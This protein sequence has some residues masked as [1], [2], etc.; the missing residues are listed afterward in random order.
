MVAI[1]IAGRGVPVDPADTVAASVVGHVR[2]VVVDTDGVIVALGRRSRVFTGSC[3]EAA[4]LQAA[5]DGDGR[6]LWPGCGRRRRCQI[7]HSE[8]WGH[9]GATDVH[10][11]GPLCGFHNRFKSRGYRCTRDPMGAWHT[12]R[13]DGTEIEAA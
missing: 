1:Q 11:A 6:C 2:R 9:G 5:L 8:E 12:Y 10:N 3:R 4:L 13:P 7:D